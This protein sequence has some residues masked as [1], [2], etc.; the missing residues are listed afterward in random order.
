MGVLGRRSGEAGGA[1][2]STESCSASISWAM[3]I[4]PGDGSRNDLLPAALPLELVGAVGFTAR[5]PLGWADF[6]LDFGRIIADLGSAS[7]RGGFRDIASG[8]RA[9]MAVRH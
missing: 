4:D 2:P 6:Q 9:D 1:K 8:R 5:P 3:S 7:A